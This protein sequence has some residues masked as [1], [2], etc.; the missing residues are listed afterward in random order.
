MNHPGE[1]TTTRDWHA[2]IDGELDQAGRTAIERRMAADPGL[3]ARLS[4]WND[5][6]VRMRARLDPVLDE[7]VPVRLML[8]R[9]DPAAG[10]RSA[11]RQRF[12]AGLAGGFA[13]GVT[14]AGLVVTAL[15]VW[16]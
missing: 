7:V 13:L 1:A 9:I 14:V 10:Q 2:F 12:V 4:S 16:R 3:A 5:L 8:S 11:E 6:G 15:G